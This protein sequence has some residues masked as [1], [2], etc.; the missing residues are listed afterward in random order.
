MQTQQIHIIGGLVLTLGMGIALGLAP[1]CG[2]NPHETQIHEIQSAVRAD[3][4]L[5]FDKEQKFRE[6]YGTYTTD[7][8]GLALAPKKALYKVGF[9]RPATGL[10]PV[11]SKY[12][13]H[14]PELKDYD[15]LKAAIP[16]LEIDYS[17]LTRLSEISLSSLENLCADCTAYPDGYKAIA[18]AN[19]D[20]DPDVDVW[21]IDHNGVINHVFDDLKQ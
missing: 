17:P 3:L 11:E 6:T 16:K 20:G 19:L 13:T 7:L 21:T 15:A 2:K 9:V 4:Q 14:R 1:Y 12:F 18:A 10:P 5:I 8:N